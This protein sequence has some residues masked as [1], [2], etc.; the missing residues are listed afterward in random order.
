MQLV[1]LLF[2]VATESAW[3]L[4]WLT[5]IEQDVGSRLRYCP[6]SEWKQFAPP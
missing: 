5:R 1:R 3:L 2:Y 4:E 6:L